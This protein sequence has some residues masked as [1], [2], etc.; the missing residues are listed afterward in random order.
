MTTL[1]RQASTRTPVDPIESRAIER[2]K[3][4]VRLHSK[5]GMTLVCFQSLSGFSMHSHCTEIPD[6]CTKS[7]DEVRAKVCP[8]FR[9]KSGDSGKLGEADWKLALRR[10]SVISLWLWFEELFVVAFEVVY[11]VG[12]ERASAGGHVRCGTQ[13]RFGAIQAT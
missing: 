9:C 4:A 6:C 1:E 5:P 12:C 7:S 2:R 3:P 8:G 13:A 10:E 11:V